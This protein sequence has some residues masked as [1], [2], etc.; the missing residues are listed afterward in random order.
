MAA[1]EAPVPEQSDDAATDSA[2][3][4]LPP[5]AASPDDLLPEGPAPDH[6]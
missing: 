3:A 6:A 4:E 2:A 1:E 5:D